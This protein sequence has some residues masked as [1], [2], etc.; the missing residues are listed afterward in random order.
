[1][2][3]KYVLIALVVDY[4]IKSKIRYQYIE[5]FDTKKEAKN[6]L[7][8]NSETLSKLLHYTGFKIEK[9]KTFS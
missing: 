8:S 1:M 6:Y 2:K 3:T 9:F 5:F 7:K 4:S